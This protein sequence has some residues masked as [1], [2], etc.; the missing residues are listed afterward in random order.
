MKIPLGGSWRAILLEGEYSLEKRLAVPEKS[1]HRT[2]FERISDREMG[3]Y[4]VVKRAKGAVQLLGMS[5]EFP[6]AEE[7]FHAL[8]ASKE[9]WEGESVARALN[10]EDILRRFFG[11]RTGGEKMVS[12]FLFGRERGESVVLVGTRSC[13]TYS[14]SPETEESLISYKTIRKVE[15]G[16]KLVEIEYLAGDEKK[17][18]TKS[19]FSHRAGEIRHMV[20][21]LALEKYALGEMD[22]RGEF[23]RHSLMEQV[24]ADFPILG[25]EKAMEVVSVTADGEPGRLILTENF[26]ITQTERETFGL[27]MAAIR[28]VRYEEDAQQVRV[29]LRDINTRLFEFYVERVETVHRLV[30]GISRKEKA[31]AVKETLFRIEMER[32]RRRAQN[33]EQS[34]PKGRGKKG[35]GVSVHEPLQE[36]LLGNE[37]NVYLY[38]SREMEDLVYS[39]ISE[40]TRA[41]LWILHL[42]L[43]GAVVSPLSYEQ[44]VHEQA[45]I[46]FETVEQ[47]KMDLVRTAPGPFPHREEMSAALFS[48]LRAFVQRNR[49][50]GYIQSQNLISFEIYRHLGESAAFYGLNCLYAKVLPGYDAPE[51]YGLSRD[52]AVFALLLAEKFPGLV[53]QLG[54]K[55]VEIRIVVAPWIVSLYT[56]AFKEEHV[57]KIFDV[58]GFEGPKFIFRLGI[59]ILEELYKTIHRARSESEIMSGI[60]KYMHEGDSPRPN[61]GEG[62]F[63][64]LIQLARGNVFVTNLRVQREREKYELM[65][66]RQM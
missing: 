47:I 7:M 57:E 1:A 55:Q 2:V 53:G 17:L 11:E 52:M 45:E 29:V 6:E 23:S 25:S 51:I 10:E 14:I 24:S 37:Y 63:R 5:K 32:E 54:E 44:A 49:K 27:P 13:L 30:Q 3:G 36:F 35:A 61:M 43:F 65:H 58:L 16:Q 12:W 62:S 39:D 66:R 26:V 34:F 59:A 15:V 60:R 22:L 8:C 31:A 20:V 18:K 9:P 38:S 42:A 50:V 19:L 33:R 46:D 28:E 56:C 48:V 21:S 40:E 4:R 64:R 41:D